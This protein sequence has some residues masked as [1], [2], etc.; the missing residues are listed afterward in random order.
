MATLESLTLPAVRGS[1]EGRVLITGPYEIRARRVPNL[2]V[3]S[4]QEGE[5]PSVDRGDPL[6]LDR[7]RGQVGLPGRAQ[8]DAEERYLFYTCVSRPTRRLY[9]SWRVAEEDGAAAARSP[10]V[11]EVAR[12]FDPAGLA[13][14]AARAPR[15]PPWARPARPAPRGGDHAPCSRA[16]PGRRRAAGGGAEAR[17]AE[18][19]GRR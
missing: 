5:F 12:V 8:H 10:F 17:S 2:F 1:G 19:A 11:D 18:P 3:A 6:L 9:L 16:R 13:L 7:D 14:R 4:L 15:P